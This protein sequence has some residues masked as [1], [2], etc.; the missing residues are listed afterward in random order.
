MALAAVPLTDPAGGSVA[1]GLAATPSLLVDSAL[2]GA[3]HVAAAA[4][5]LPLL[6]SCAL[7]GPVPSTVKALSGIKSV[8]AESVLPLVELVRGASVAAGT[9]GASGAAMM[10]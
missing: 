6:V 4:V 9:A 7:A 1:A 3:V 5:M 8:D 2:A 10:C